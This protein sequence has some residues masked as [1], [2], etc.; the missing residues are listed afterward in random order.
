MSTSD[1]FI[2]NDL[3]NI[4]DDI[5]EPSKE[6]WNDLRG[7]GEVELQVV[8]PD[9]ITLHSSR[10]LFDHHIMQCLMFGSPMAYV[11]CIYAFHMIREA[12]IISGN[13]TDDILTMLCMQLAGEWGD[14]K[15]PAAFYNVV[16]VN[17]MWQE[18]G[19]LPALPT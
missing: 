1:Y 12:L 9:E 5:L 8:F 6:Q 17:R 16:E 11:S 3:A 13:W 19:L 2:F 4:D 10:R 15:V 14:F 18:Q 7:T